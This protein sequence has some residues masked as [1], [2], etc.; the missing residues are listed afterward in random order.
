MARSFAG[1][2]TDLI[3]TSTTINAALGTIS[4]WANPNWN[5]GD[6][7]QR[8]FY[9][10][11]TDFPSFQR[12]SDNNIYAGFAPSRVVIADTGLFTSGT[13]A[14]WIITF[15]Q[16]TP[17]Q[18]LYKNGVSKG[19][20]GGS[21]SG[22][23]TPP[24]LVG[25]QGSGF[26]GSLNG[27]MADFTIWN[28]VLSAL[29]ITALANGARPYTIRPSALLCWLPLDG[30]ASPEPDLSG[31]AK[32]GTITGTITLAFGPPFAPFTPRWPL[33]GILPFTPPP[34]FVLMPQ[35]VM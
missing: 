4:C 21:F 33:G 8:F 1:A 29:E 20:N 32:N 3:S 15:N 18:T 31:N 2:V 25:N 27:K 9:N 28:V 6:G 7:V 14:N 26:S 23:C 17:L 12:Y 22:T 10:C 16:S 30:L 13:W 34:A 24:I 19:T 35:I 11:S 5:S